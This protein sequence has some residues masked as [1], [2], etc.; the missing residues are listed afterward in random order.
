MKI[1]QIYYE[2]YELRSIKIAYKHNK[3]RRF[4]YA[5]DVECY[6]NCVI[7]LEFDVVNQLRRQP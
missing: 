7:Y 6:E 4:K 1:L 2:Y 5:N 3:P